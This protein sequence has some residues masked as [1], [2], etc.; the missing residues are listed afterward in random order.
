MGRVKSGWDPTGTSEDDG[1]RHGQGIFQQKNIC[2]P[3]S[4][5]GAA[6]AA[7]RGREN[8]QQKIICDTHLHK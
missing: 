7:R 8:F 3:F 6:E 2:D 1:P 5:A 4:K